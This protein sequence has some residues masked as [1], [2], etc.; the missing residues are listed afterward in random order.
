MI[1]LNDI[2]KKECDNFKNI[3][4]VDSN[5]ILYNNN[6]YKEYIKIKEKFVQVR[7]YD[8]KHFTKEGASLIMEDVIK[9]IYNN[10]KFEGIPVFKR[11][12]LIE[13]K[14]F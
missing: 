11:D 13:I 8:G 14:D 1:K 7:I 10:F 5:K 3:L 9:I 2:I 4:F 6:E 12:K